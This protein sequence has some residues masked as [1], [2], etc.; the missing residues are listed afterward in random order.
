MLRVKIYSIEDDAA[1]PKVPVE[2]GIATSAS[3]E[4][5]NGGRGG[6]FVCISS[7]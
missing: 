1:E 4:K 6:G 3:T 2:D 7:A 5:N